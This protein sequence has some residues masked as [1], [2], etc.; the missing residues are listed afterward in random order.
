MNRKIIEITVKSIKVL[1]IGENFSKE[2]AN[3][4]GFELYYPRE[5]ASK[6]VTLKSVEIENGKVKPFRNIKYKD[7]IIFKEVVRGDFQLKVFVTTQDKL[8][9]F[10]KLMVTLF[11]GALNVALGGLTSGVGSAVLGAVATNGQELFVD[12][13][14]AEDG[15]VAIIGENFTALTSDNIVDGDMEFNLKAPKDIPRNRNRSTDSI[16]GAIQSASSSTPYIKKD[17][18]NGKVILTFKVL[19]EYD[20]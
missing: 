14:K 20:D 5:G 12:S 1:K 10:S 6:I 2:D 3:L 4:L 9:K 16:Y 7:K 15:G 18:P 11:K 13:I 17:S 8:T 19:H